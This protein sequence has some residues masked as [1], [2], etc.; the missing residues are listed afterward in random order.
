MN[1]FI[2]YDVF[3]V[4]NVLSNKLQQKS[5]TL[6]KAAVIIK[7]VIETL[8]KREMMIHFWYYGEK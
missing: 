4:I 1:L 8:E 3:I 5:A 6:G 7:A 2:F